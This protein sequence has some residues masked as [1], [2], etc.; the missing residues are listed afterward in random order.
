MRD[1]RQKCIDIGVPSPDRRSHRGHKIAA[2]VEVVVDLAVEDD[3]KAPADRLQRLGAGGAKV[4]DRQP[5]TA[6]PSSVQI[7]SASGP[8]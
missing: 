4:K 5:P 6:M 1:P 3:N 8:R 2:Q 7:P